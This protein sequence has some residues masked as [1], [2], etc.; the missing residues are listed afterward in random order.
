MRV[1][2]LGF[3]NASSN[4]VRSSCTPLVWVDLHK[5]TGALEMLKG[6]A[7]FRE[8]ETTGIK[9]RKEEGSGLKKL[10]AQ[11]RQGAWRMDNRDSG[12]GGG[13][14]GRSGGCSIFRLGFKNTQ[15]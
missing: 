1:D 14:G 9:V 7:S 10:K 2:V 3:D 11:K 8:D 15:D 5:S 4:V 6:I 13:G 12:S